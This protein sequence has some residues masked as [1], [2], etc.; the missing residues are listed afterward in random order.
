MNKPLYTG[1]SFYELIWTL[2]LRL[3]AVIGIIYS[4]S[5]YDENPAVILFIS[6]ISLALILILGDDQ[7]I[8]YSDKITQS[9]NS[10]ASLIFNSKGLTYQIQDIKNAYL[11]PSTTSPT[12]IGAGILLALI[13]QKQNN[14]KSR[15][16][17]LEMKNGETIRL[18]TKLERNKMK[19]IVETV[20][21][22]TSKN[23]H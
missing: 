3:A 13:M 20:N 10:F 11:Q 18:E 6:I 22:L 21:S 19:K 12:E 15:P 2:F 7:I 14:D 4:L 16:I 5:H 9:T 8:V 1:F 23:S 17:F